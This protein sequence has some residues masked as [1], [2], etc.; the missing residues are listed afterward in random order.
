VIRLGEVAHGPQQ[1]F[2]DGA[3]DGSKEPKLPIFCDA[4]NVGLDDVFIVTE[5]TCCGLTL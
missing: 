2:E 5:A 3:G 4:A 1:T